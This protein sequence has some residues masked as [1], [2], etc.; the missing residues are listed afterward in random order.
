MSLASRKLIQAT[1]GAGGDTGDDDFANVVLLLDG[2]GTSG[3]QNETFTDSSTNGFTVTET[4]SVVQGSFS[5]YGDNWSN[6]FDG[7]SDALTI[8][9]STDFDFGTGDFTME[10]W[11]YP[12]AF[13]GNYNQ[14]NII[15]A[16]EGT[17]NTAYSFAVY[18]DGKVQLYG[19][20]DVGGAHND[21]STST[22]SL[23][24]WT[25][26]MVTRSSGTVRFF[27]NGTLD[28]ST[29]TRTGNYNC[30]SQGL[31]IGKQ[32]IDNGGAGATRYWNGWLSNVRMIKGTALQTSSFTP[33]TTPLTAVTNTVLL[34]CQSNRF[35]DNSSS[36]HTLTPTGTASATPFSPFK[37]SNARTLTTDGGSG[38]FEGSGDYLSVGGVTT[39]FDFGTGDF[40]I[41]CWVN[42]KATGQF[43][44]IVLFGRDGNSGITCDISSSNNPRIVAHIGGS[45][46]VVATGSTSLTKD[47]WYHL[48]FVRNGSSFKIYVNG[49]EDASVTN[50][51]SITAVS[52]DA[53][54]VKQIGYFRTS[55]G[56]DR[57]FN[58][59]ISSLRVVK[60]TAVYTSTFTP[61]TAP[62]TAVTNTELLTNFQDAGIYDRS[63]IN[64]LDTVGNAQIDTAVKKYGTGSIEFDGTGD[65]LETPYD[66][67]YEFGTGDFTVEGW[68]NISTL[69]TGLYHAPL[70][71]FGGANSSNLSS[72]IFSY[73]ANSG[74][75][76]LIFYRFDGTTET[77][78]GRSWTPS[79]NQWYHIAVSRN[80]TDLRLFVD[81]V[82]LGAT[83]TSSLDYSAVGTQGLLVGHIRTGASGSTYSYLD[84]YADDLRVTKGVARYTSNFTAP[85][86]AL[87][88][89]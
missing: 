5:P 42:L 79:A 85:T 21:F 56:A 15:S 4:G 45:W 59:Y 22:V 12:A 74:S 14:N 10:A 47:Q 77:L 6:S 80:G 16:H 61:P 82:Q 71:S 37:D 66:D 33:S 69:P 60:G 25:H 19:G 49:V 43:N 20:G 31:A 9:D 67:V 24:E 73:Y 40:T 76:Q 39:E 83:F 41:E 84:G 70:V 53:S 52:S 68:I 48:A 87:P 29:Y 26:V 28:A 55:A 88:K 7:N 62:L 11:I 72:W 3:D 58:G 57:Y 27:I 86:A 78:L 81:G 34:A 38:Y 44:H 63:G 89:F 54:S 17:D 46:G 8:P 35:V 64:N 30:T 75:G 36:S 2:D 32:P 51:G 65:Y 18:S 23:N 50:A 13:T 1:A